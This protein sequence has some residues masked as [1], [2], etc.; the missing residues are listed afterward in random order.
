[1]MAGDNSLFKWVDANGNSQTGD[2]GAPGHYAQLNQQGTGWGYS[3]DPTGASGWNDNWN[4][5]NS[6]NAQQQ[7]AAATAATG[8]LQTSSISYG[9]FDLGN[10]GGDVPSG[11]PISDDNPISSDSN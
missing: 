1:M 4:F 7:A 8:G 5:L 2:F 10:Q 9:N 11:E 6:N 3:T